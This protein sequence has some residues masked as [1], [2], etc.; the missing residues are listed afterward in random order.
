MRIFLKKKRVLK[1][2]FVQ[3]AVVGG[4]MQVCKCKMLFLLRVGFTH[5][6]QLRL[7]TKKT[8]YLRNKVLRLHMDEQKQ[9]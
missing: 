2:F 4:R 9:L 5:N 7:R 8:P 3:C 1:G 6:H